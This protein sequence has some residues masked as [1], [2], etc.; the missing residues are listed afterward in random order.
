MIYSKANLLVVDM[1]KADKGI[2]A[3]DNVHFCPDGTTV[4]AN[5]S[6]V[7]AVSPVPTEIQ[8]KVPLDKEE[9][10]EV[11][12]I[13]G[14][15]ISSETVREVL[16]GMPKDTMFGGLL[17]HCSESGGSF[18]LT[19]GKRSRSISGKAWPREYVDYKGIF[20]RTLSGVG[21]IRVVCNLRRLVDVLSVMDKMFPDS[22]KNLR[23]F[24][25]FTSENDIVIRVEG[26]DK[27]Q[28]GI[29]VLKSYSGLEAEWIVDNEGWEKKLTGTEEGRK[30]CKIKKNAK[31]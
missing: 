11:V 21:E 27:R 17:E 14:D 4:G 5:G 28:R 31:K 20:K 7:M 18:G 30:P 19:D 12:D 1:T 24:M 26:V 25:E 6:C 9:S 8:E 2:P 22:S 16:R 13:G 29:A 23:V 3:L 15:T 10:G